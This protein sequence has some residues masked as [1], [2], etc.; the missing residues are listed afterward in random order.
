MA[1]SDMAPRL[2]DSVERDL[3]EGW[4]TLLASCFVSRSALLGDKDG[5]SVKT[6][7]RLNMVPF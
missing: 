6:N 4:E 2:H 1:F 3:C 7:N 5:W